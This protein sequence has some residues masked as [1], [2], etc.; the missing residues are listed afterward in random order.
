MNNE[1]LISVCRAFGIEGDLINTKT[2]TDG[3]INS[4]YLAEFDADGK[5]TK[6]LVQQ[7]NTHVFKDPDVLM[8]NITGVTKYLR[9]TIEKDGGDPDRETLTFIKSVDGKYYHYLE[10]GSCW[11]IY[12]FIDDSFTFDL[13]D[14]NEVFESAGESFGRFQCLL[15]G[16]PAEK[17]GETIP[18]F[19]DTPKRLDALRLSAESDVCGR[20]ES[21]KAELDFAFSRE[22]CAATAINLHEE[23]K[24]P[25]R[26]THN[27]TKLN[28]ILFDRNTNKGICVIDLDTI[29]PGFSLYDFG[30]AIRFGAKTALE[31]EADLSKVSISMP[32]Y[33]SYVKGYLSSCASALTKAEVDH[34][35]FSAK[36]L[37]YECGVRFLTD[38][39]DGDVYFKTDYP[40]H[41]LVR[42]RNQFKMVEEI[43]KHLDEMN[44]ITQKIY[45]EMMAEA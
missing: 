25:L 28:N 15:D 17:L 35:A 44:S 38:Y 37:T 22:D 8:N 10:D 12:C 42:A 5:N 11:R 7:I 36:L 13:I 4:T 18:N 16:Y 32:L 34:L 19:H 20:A 24:I 14:S 23:G 41:N 45:A 31:D 1:S 9:D 26:V 40:E 39:L 29:M 27:D 43:E 30:D 33:E 21:V 2:F 6:Y 3:H